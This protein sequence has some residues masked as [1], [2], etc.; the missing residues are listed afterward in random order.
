MGQEFG[1]RRVYDATQKKA[2]GVSLRLS[3][4]EVELGGKEFGKL[5]F[6]SLALVVGERQ[7]A[8]IAARAKHIGIDK[9]ERTGMAGWSPRCKAPVSSTER[10]PF[11]R[12]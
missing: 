9:F 11:R 12:S 5:V 4:R 1:I 6:E 7:V 3:D 2:A 10:T 8:R